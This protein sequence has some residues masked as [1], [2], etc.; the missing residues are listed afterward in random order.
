MDLLDLRARSYI[1]I[2]K[3]DLA[4]KDAKAMR[5]IGRT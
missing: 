2:G 3:L 4:M 5:K 1:A